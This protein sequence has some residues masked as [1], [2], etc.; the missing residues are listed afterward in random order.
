[1]LVLNRVQRGCYINVSS[2]QGGRGAI[3]KN[4]YLSSVQGGIIFI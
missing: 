3:F 2:G 1:M 4:I